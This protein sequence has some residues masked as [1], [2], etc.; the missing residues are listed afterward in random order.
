MPESTDETPTP[1]DALAR[2]ETA[3]AVREAVTTL[4]HDLSVCVLLSEYEDQSQA[5]IAEALG[6]TTKA[7]E[8]R[9]YRA[10]Q[11]LRE[12]LA[13]WLAA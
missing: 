7:V 2:Q 4:P 12:K 5:E 8:T 10:R 11:L 1:D 6:C 3:N 13:R 9:L